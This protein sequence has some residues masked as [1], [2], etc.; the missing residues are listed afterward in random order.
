M[1]KAGVVA[2]DVRLRPAL[3]KQADDEF[4]REARAADNRLSG[5]HRRV[6]HDLVVPLL[7]KRTNIDT[8]PSC[9]G[10]LSFMFGSS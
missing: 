10:Y 2:E 1:G 4:H 7:I 6:N 3:G 8:L 9:N 5:K